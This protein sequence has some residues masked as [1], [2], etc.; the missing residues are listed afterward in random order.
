MKSS[1]KMGR[2]EASNGEIARKLTGGDLPGMVGQSLCP[3]SRGRVVDD[4]KPLR[5]EWVDETAWTSITHR[6]RMASIPLRSALRL[7]G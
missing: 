3:N 4:A 1:H 5:S 6:M 2:R 7:R